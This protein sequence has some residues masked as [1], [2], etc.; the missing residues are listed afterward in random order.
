M[1]ETATV[2]TILICLIAFL[3]FIAMIV[4]LAMDS[5]R[6]DKWSNVYAFSLHAYAQGMHGSKQLTSPFLSKVYVTGSSGV[7][8]KD[9]SI[10]THEDCSSIVFGNITT[11]DTEKHMMKCRMMRSAPMYLADV[12]RSWSVL[13]A[14]STRTLTKHILLIF[15]V[16]NIFWFCQYAHKESQQEKHILPRLFGNPM[17]RNVVVFVAVVIFGAT[18]GSDINSDLST[19]VA[20][21]SVSTAVSFV[22]VCLLIICFEYAGMKTDTIVDKPKSTPADSEKGQKVDASDEN[23][24]IFEPKVEHMHRNIY[25]SYVLLL[26]FPMVVVFMLSHT[27][28]AIVDVH[29]QLV[30][31][32]FMFYAALDVFQTRTTSVLL[33]LHDIPRLETPTPVNRDKPTEAERTELEQVQTKNALYPKL[34]KDVHAVRLF[35]VLAFSLCKLFAL[36]PALVLLQ[37]KYA[38]ESYQHVMLVMHYVVL[39]T[40]VF[41]DCVQ[42][43]YSKLPVDVMKL[44]IIWVYIVSIFY[45]TIAVDLK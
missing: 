16:F 45:A 27:H 17:H 39:I 14:Q 13:G 31:F 32:S 29:I 12:E 5:L 44:F 36:V 37:T 4:N 30:F 40:F 18:L 41:A 25:M 24:G 20:I 42:I 7:A 2:R 34:E 15:I 19:A 23:V 35:V 6:K 1:P 43:V 21:G 10:A 28:K 8:L 9:N 26:M 33:C 11:K 38:E 22:V 3:A